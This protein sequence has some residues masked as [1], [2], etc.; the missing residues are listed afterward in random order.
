MAYSFIDPTENQL[1]VM[2]YIGS[3]APRGSITGL[4]E[5]KWYQIVITQEKHLVNFKKSLMKRTRLAVNRV[6]PVLEMD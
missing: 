5:G 1:D 6:K 3:T 2:T 4:K